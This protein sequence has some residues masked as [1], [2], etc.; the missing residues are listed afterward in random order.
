MTDLELRKG[1]FKL[2]HIAELK[3]ALI[4]LGGEEIAKRVI[5]T[6]ELSGAIGRRGEDGDHIGGVGGVGEGPKVG[7]GEANSFRII[8]GGQGGKGGDGGKI[9][10][11]VGESKKPETSHNA[12]ADSGGN[13][14]VGRGEAAEGLVFSELLGHADKKTRSAEPK[15]LTASVDD[16]DLLNLLQTHGFVT[17]GGLFEVTGEELRQAGFSVGQI[18]TLRT[19]VE[20]FKIGK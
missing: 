1:N 19:M 16:K 17:V 5:P 20:T 4:K 11:S 3:W 10:D 15:Q 8:R 13:R 2:G 7:V 14:G 18:N 9:D 12:A 6:L